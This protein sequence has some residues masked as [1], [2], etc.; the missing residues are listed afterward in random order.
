M[1]RRGLIKSGL[2]LG[3]LASVGGGSLFGPLS[4]AAI[5]GTA[6]TTLDRTYGLGTP[7]DARG[8]KPIVAKSGE[9]HLF[10]NDLGGHQSTTALTDRKP[11]LT[12]VQ[13]SDVHLA[14][15]QSPMRTEWLD[16]FED[17]DA[18]GDPV[19]GLLSSAYRAHEMLSLHVAD[20]MIRTINDIR[21]GPVTGKP[22][23]FVIQTGDNS[24]NCQYNEV[25]W[26]IDVLDGT[27]VTPDSGNTGKYEGVMSANPMIY[28]IHYWHPDGTPAG[29]VDDLA[30][31]RYGFPVVK[32]L[33]E[34]SRKTFKPAGLNQNIPWYTAFGNHD[35]LVQGNFPHS[36]QLSLVGTGPLKIISSPAGVSE[37]DVLNLAR[38]QNLTGVLN[39]VSLLS[40]ATLVTPDL[41]RR[42]L[43]RS[44]IVEQ[45][46]TTP[47]LP[48]PVGHG[49]TTTNRLQGTA[50]YTFIQ[51]GVQ[52]IVLDTV[53]PN[54]WD[55]GSIDSAQLAW[56]TGLLNAP[57]TKTLPAVIASHHTINTMTNQLPLAGL[58]LNYRETGATVQA[59][60]L[61]NPRVIAWVNGHTHV[62][63]I[64]AHARADGSGGFWEINT[65]SHIDF[66][67]Q[68]RLLEITDNLDG[69]L[70]IFTT[71]L[72]HAGPAAHTN[73]TD[74]VQLAG[75][76]RELAAN[77]W[78]S[79]TTHREGVIEARNTEL[80]VPKPAVLA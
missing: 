6:L 77:D 4:E 50:Y 48:G 27:S 51:S 20:A 79:R 41:N 40:T 39:A 67:Q 21:C 37:A 60:L 28:D 18:P 63:Q 12:F 35:G 13:L 15:H 69:T 70:S 72:D 32:G 61:A 14:D 64:W 7:N 31:S 43:T 23:A 19:P 10:R 30:R 58:D 33:L 1:S 38:T 52:F 34:S 80:L 9:P 22:I 45:H 76:S 56:L 16:R 8:Y 44:Q 73:I 36:L 42:S 25:R 49:F 66:P 29:K 5:A 26:N 17:Q 62:N 3:G 57:A 68:A 78:Q 55:D 46:F 71:M 74:P 24:D 2:V 47:P 59:L 54:G 65:A 53:N 75:L 11:V